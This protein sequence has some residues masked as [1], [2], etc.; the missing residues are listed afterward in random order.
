MRTPVRRIRGT[1]AVLLSALLALAAAPR[2]RVSVAFGEKTIAAD[3]AV[4]SL[5][6][7]FGQARVLGVVE[8]EADVSCGK[9]RV[10][11]A[12]NGRVRGTCAEV[13]INGGVGPRGVEACFG[14]V[15]VR[16]TVKGP[17]TMT[18][19]NVVLGPDASVDGRVT[20]HAG[21]FQGDRARVAGG[22]V[23]HNK[24]RLHGCLPL[25]KDAEAGLALLLGL[26]FGFGV[27]VLGWWLVAFLLAGVVFY[28]LLALIFRDTLERR[29]L[30][31]PSENVG[32]D[33]LAGALAIGAGFLTGVTLCVSC[34]GVPL[35]AVLS[36]AYA[37]AY[38]FGMVTLGYVVG[39]AVW[40][41]VFRKTAG[42]FATVLTGLITVQVSRLVPIIGG[43]LG[44]FY[45]VLAIG[46]TTRWIYEARRSRPP[47]VVPPPVTPAPPKAS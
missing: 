17:I 12:V 43:V 40:S 13:V 1:G 9:L 38:W 4:Q 16:G 6:V 33:F 44:M 32:L 45:C 27:F 42:F 8:G 46:M 7:S 36:L 37:V 11:G 23:E 25:G 34:V 2:E 24:V 31:F 29:R 14:S 39:G 30:L 20:I 22:V 18:A 35:L 47:P 26:L 19:G 10:D 15:V 5:S 41:G 21:R 28:L 3:E